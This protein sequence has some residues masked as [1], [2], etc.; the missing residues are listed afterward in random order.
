M[1]LKGRDGN[2]YFCA[3]HRNRGIVVL[4]DGMSFTVTTF[5]AIKTENISH[6]E[7]LRMLHEFIV[8][9]RSYSGRT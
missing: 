7:T 4:P 8:D 6:L 5:E 9:N 1:V 2:A 3:S